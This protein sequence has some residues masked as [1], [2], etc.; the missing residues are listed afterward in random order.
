MTQRIQEQVRILPAIKTKAHFVQICREMLCGDAM[1][2]SN[3]AALQEGKCRFD[4]IGMDV[5]VNIDL[6]LMLDRFMLRGKCCA[7]K[8]R[9]IGVEFV[10]NDHFN[11]FAHI[12]SDILRQ[13]S[14]LH[15]LSMEE[16]QIAATLP[17][18]DYDLLV[19]IAVSGLTV[20][21]LLPAQIRFVYFNSTVHHRALCFFHGSTN[22]MTEIPR[23]F[24]ADSECALDLIRAHALACLTEKQ[25][26]KKPLLQG[27][28]GIVEDRAS[29]DAELIIA[30]LA[31]EQLLRSSEFNYRAVASQT[32]NAVRP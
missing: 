20:G 18:A 4:R 8:G 22:P 23:C 17:D 11:I 16:P 26:S 32:F 6:R 30:R 2:C 24:V 27:K 25:G 28:M 12:V 14:S 29:G 21:V 9:G 15:V 3:D 31:V 10:G 5:A 19:G 13:S 7:A 1:P